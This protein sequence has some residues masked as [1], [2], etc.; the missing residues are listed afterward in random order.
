MKRMILCISLCLTAIL[1]G[2]IGIYNLK[3][4]TEKFSV[5]L[6]KI[7]K[8][9]SDGDLNAALEEAESA[10]KTWSKSAKYAAFY[11]EQD[12]I[13]EIGTSLE[14]IIGFL[15]ADSEEVYGECR[16]L[17]SYLTYVYKTQIPVLQNIF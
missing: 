6:D 9:Y 1:L 4:C 13:L 8:L 3:S 5:Q 7:E 10:R 2:I 16:N 14:R 15:R 12:K 11:L 17:G